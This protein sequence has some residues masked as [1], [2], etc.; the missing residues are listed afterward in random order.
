[1]S[2]YDDDPLC[3]RMGRKVDHEATNE[4]RRAQM[5]GIRRVAGAFGVAVKKR[6]GKVVPPPPNVMAVLMLR[7]SRDASYPPGHGAK[8]QKRRSKRRRLR[9]RERF[10]QRQTWRAFFEEEKRRARGAA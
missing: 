4:A 3:G 10:L 6:D 8:T 1:M 7:G 2:G 9:R 5:V